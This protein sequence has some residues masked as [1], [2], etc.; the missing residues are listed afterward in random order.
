MKIVQIN[1]LCDRGSTG[2]ICA[3]I[4]RLL[5]KEGIE[6]YIFYSIGQS[7][8][9]LGKKFASKY[10]IKLQALKS[11][12]F[13]NYG[14][15]SHA[16]TRKLIK[17]LRK[18]N[19]DVVQLHNIHNQDVNLKMLFDYFRETQVKVFWTF[20]DC[21]AFTAYCPHF[22]MSKCDY[23]K[24][25]CHSCPQRRRFSWFFDRSKK[26]YED[27][28]AIFDGINLTVITPSKWLADVA[29]QSFLRDTDIRVINNGIDLDIF[30][31]QESDFRDKYNLEN[32][33]IILGVADGWGVRKGLD[34]FIKLSESLPH[35]YQIVL[36]GTNDDVD[37]QLPSNIIS[38]HRT[39]SQKELAKIYAS[40]NVFANPTR[41][42]TFPT[43]N[44][45]AL[46]C[47]TPIV[48]FKTGGSPEIIDEKTGIV[49]DV[50]DIDGFKNAIIEAAE[51]ENITRKSCLERAKRY[52]RKDRY[53]DYINLYLMR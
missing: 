53:E 17:E 29:K 27:K 35:N 15:N 36:V 1:A 18:I 3:D 12:I 47:G 33:K 16:S 44:M 2:R 52:N 32:K 49:V 34:V 6:N 37:K 25:G 24:T 22:V 7:E 9:P 42:D 14:F 13:G 39:N 48:T 26:M 30:K 43:V 31:P 10:Y 38:I 8:Y 51:G 28:K 19:P 4:S 46:A 20:H 11:R 23:W 21:W 40:A 5:T 50:D 45:E 41:E